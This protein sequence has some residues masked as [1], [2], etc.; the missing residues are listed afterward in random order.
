MVHPL[1]DEKHCIF[2]EMSDSGLEK[3]RKKILYFLKNPVHA[4]VIAK[5]GHDFTMKY[6]RTSN[7]IDEILK[8][9]T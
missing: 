9:I 7:R 8:V 6:H 1:I 2:Y 4:A 3:L 5:T